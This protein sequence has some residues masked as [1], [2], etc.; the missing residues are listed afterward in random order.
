MAGPISAEPRQERP[1]RVRVPTLTREETERRAARAFDA[2][3]ASVIRAQFVPPPAA[4]INAIRSIVERGIR[5]GRTVEIGDVLDGY[6]A[7]HPASALARYNRI[8]RGDTTWLMSGGRVG[9]NRSEF[10]RLSASYVGTARPHVIEALVRLSDPRNRNTPIDVSSLD[11]DIV[12]ALQQELSSQLR[13][14]R[15]QLP[16]SISH[17]RP[18]Q[19]LLFAN[20]LPPP[21][22]EADFGKGKG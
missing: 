21:P 16:A 13:A 5:E 7:E 6:C 12:A 20:L 9:F 11:Q 10:G 2:A 22:Q 19:R 14:G 8:F 3:L 17:E 1:P 15:N 18:E 4:E